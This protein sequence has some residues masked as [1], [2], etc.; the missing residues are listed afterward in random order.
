[1]LVRSPR[2]GQR[3][4][5]TVILSVHRF[6][7][8]SNQTG[9]LQALADRLLE[10]GLVANAGRFRDPPGTLKIR[11]RDANGNG[12]SCVFLGLLHKTLQ[13]FRI[14]L[15]DLQPGRPV[16]SPCSKRDQTRAASDGGPPW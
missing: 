10:H 1:M 7:A 14:G 11:N 2:T 3:S 13:Q 16:E 8:P 4:G 5:R 12:A 15:G 9:S 6:P